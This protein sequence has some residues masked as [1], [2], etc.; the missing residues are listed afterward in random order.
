L[1]LQGWLQADIAE[2]VGISAA[3]VC[4]DLKAL[5]QQW[6]KSALVDFDE[7]KARELAKVDRLEREYW[8]AWLAS[9]EEK[10]ST[11]T[12]TATTK[13]GKRD[14]AQI[15]REERNGDPR[16]LQGV[17][18]CIEKRCKILGVDAA[19]KLDIKVSDLDSAI[20]RELARM[21][22]SSVAG[23]DGNSND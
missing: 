9:K 17:Q 3:T 11:A 15:R 4:R 7:A 14:K 2:E 1:Y 23:A 6:V 10:M 16:Y 8:E 19:Q 12:E 20:E 18:W 5:Q 13:D 21:A 22:D